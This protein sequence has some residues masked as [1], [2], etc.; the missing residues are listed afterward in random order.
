MRFVIKTIATTED[1]KTG[2]KTDRQV[3]LHNDIICQSAADHSN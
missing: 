1:M 3:D 2:K